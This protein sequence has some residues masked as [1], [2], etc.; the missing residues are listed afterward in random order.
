MLNSNLIFFG[1]SRTSPFTIEELRALVQKQ[2]SILI[3]KLKKTLELQ[4]IQTKD[5]YFMHQVHGTDGDVINS[6]V[7]T[8]FEK[9]GDFIITNIPNL[10]IGILTADCLPIIFYDSTNNTTAIAH[11]GWRGTVGNICEKVVTAMTS[12]FKS[13]VENIEVYFGPCAK[14]CCY[15]VDE[16]FHTNIQDSDLKEKTLLKK[17]NKTYFNIP[18]Y[19]KLLLEECNIFNINIENNICTIC[20]NN[21]WS[22]RRDKEKSGLQISLAMLK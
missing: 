7:P 18:Y 22:Y 12:T 5:L 1:N 16:N 6:Q 21:F 14:I 20:S 17:N 9:Q 4:N 3:D 19:N 13:S 11:A 15:E 8:S 10:P 2:N